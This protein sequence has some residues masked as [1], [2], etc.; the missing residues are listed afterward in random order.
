M[1]RRYYNILK[2][3]ANRQ[4][5]C[6]LIVIFGLF[7][8]VILPGA[9]NSLAYY[10][11]ETQIIDLSFALPA[12]QLY[13]MVDAYGVRGRQLYAIIEVTVDL[14]YPIVY[15][16]LM[17]LLLTV[18]HRKM[19]LRHYGILWFPIGIMIIDY[20]ENLGIVLMLLLFPAEWMPLAVSVS[21]LTAIKW[22]LVCA[23]VLLILG[24]SVRVATLYLRGDFGKKMS[25]NP[26]I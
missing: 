6:L 25:N 10:S 24:L 14:I 26:K 12:T 23:N 21:L 22:T 3:L 5:I 18:L 8:A 19:N 7:Q 1:A 15:T 2:Q 13:E 17:S 9:A 20:L 4:T 11:G 16:L